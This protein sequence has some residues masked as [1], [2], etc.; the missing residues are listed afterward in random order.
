MKGAKIAG[1]WTNVRDPWRMAQLCGRMRPMMKSRK[2]IRQATL[3]RSVHCSGIGLHSGVPVNMTLRPAPED[4]GISFLRRDLED[5]A[6]RIPVNP[7]AVSDTMLGT[8]V[9]NGRGGRVLTI[10]HLMSAFAGLGIDNAEIELDAEEIPI[11]DGSAA[12]FVVLVESAGVKWQARARRYIRI[13]R[14]VVVEDGVKRAALSPAGAT[15]FEFEIDFPTPV[16]GRQHYALEV[17]PDSFKVE[18][19]RAR[20]FGFLQ[21][22]DALRAMGLA[23]G[24]SL[25]N[26][27]V[28]DG[29][30]VVNP[31]GLR[32]SDEFVRH[33]L[34]DAMG[35]LYVLG[36]PI[37]GRYAARRSG[38]TLNNALVRALLE[39][40]SAFEVIPRSPQAAFRPE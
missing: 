30:R 26:A 31:E 12:G 37:M 6:R 33:K 8:T 4:S 9:S 3:A 23:Q 11:L 16:I 32:F 27:I 2:E 28:I 14:P 25:D 35:D 39:Q 5:E 29:D 19:A 18:I 7:Q 38:H 24:G 17:T 22:V 36:M 1:G 21:D 15:E 40:K 13:R 34:L 10:E 20:T